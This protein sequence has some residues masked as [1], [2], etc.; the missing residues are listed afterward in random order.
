MTHFFTPD[1]ALA[2][3]PA[4]FSGTAMEVECY[5]S[6]YLRVEIEMKLYNYRTAGV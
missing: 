2:G 4:D 6:E 5:W 3:S 1:E